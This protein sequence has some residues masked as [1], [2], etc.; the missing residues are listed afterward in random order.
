MLRDKEDI[1]N[2]EEIIKYTQWF[3]SKFNLTF[4]EKE[5]LQQLCMV[6]ILEVI[7][8]YDGRTLLSTFLY[9]PCRTVVYNYLRKKQHS[10]NVFFV[11]D[12]ILNHNKYYR[13][14]KEEIEQDA[15]IPISST[16]K[17]DKLTVYNK[18]KKLSKRF[19]QLKFELGD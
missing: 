2:T 1:K 5:D 16:E 19:S 8:Q 14:I 10:S 4:D 18:I 6:R 3:I 12:T 7:K 11:D 13:D 9:Y 15:E 17:S